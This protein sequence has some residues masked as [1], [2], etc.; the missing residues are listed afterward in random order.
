LPVTLGKRPSAADNDND[1]I[2][3]TPAPTKTSSPTFAPTELATQAPTNVPPGVQRTPC[4]NDCSG[5]GD[6]STAAACKC[7][8]G[9][10]GL[11]CSQFILRAS[12]LGN[13]SELSTFGGRTAKLT[14]RVATLDGIPQAPNAYVE[15]RAACDPATEAVVQGSKVTLSPNSTSAEVLLLGVVEYKDDGL[16]KFTVLIGPCSS[17]DP[18]F[19]FASW[20]G[21]SP[22]AW[23]EDYPFPFVED[24]KPK[25]S[26]QLGELVVLTGRHFRNDTKVCVDDIDVSGPPVVRVSMKLANATSGFSQ[27]SEVQLRSD[28]A[29]DWFKNVTGRAY[30]PNVYRGTCGVRRRVAANPIVREETVLE[31]GNLTLKVV[32]GAYIPPE[33]FLGEVTASLS[34]SCSPPGIRVACLVR[35]R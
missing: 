32:Q 28:F 18:R 13:V 16:Q 15:C 29:K 11:D 3:D 31:L 23:N 26:S 22:S 14:V 7:N 12:I 2:P 25:A 10:I 5:N 17:T 9:W 24:I 4:L 21:P 27:Y 30:R 35:T 20:G 6:C 19:N 33:P 34:F 1:G 8:G